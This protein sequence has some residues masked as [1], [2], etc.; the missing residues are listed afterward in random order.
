M[1][2][3]FSENQTPPQNFN[4]SLLSPVNNRRRLFQQQ[5]RT[6]RVLNFDN[7]QS[8]LISPRSPLQRSSSLSPISP[9]ALSPSISPS[10]DLFMLLRKSSPDGYLSPSS[11]PDGYLRPFSSISNEASPYRRSPSSRSPSPSPLLKSQLLDKD[12][13]ELNFQEILNGKP[14]YSDLIDIYGKYF[15]NI[16]DFLFYI[17]KFKDHKTNSNVW[18]W[19]AYYMSQID[20]DN[21]IIQYLNEI[22]KVIAITDQDPIRVFI[23]REKDEYFIM[24]LDSNNRYSTEDLDENGAIKTIQINHE[25]ANELLALLYSSGVYLQDNRGLKL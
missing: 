21:G 19:I 24:I 13:R 11:S 23:V 15:D 5:T 17:M 18:T 7:S 9:V 3:H 1:S 10:E 20:N 12:P 25:D 4:F 2:R 6:Q 8:P 14:L 16:S 22:R